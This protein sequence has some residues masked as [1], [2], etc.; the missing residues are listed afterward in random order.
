MA[1]AINYG[2]SGAAPGQPLP[3]DHP[4]K[5]FAAD[6]PDNHPVKTLFTGKEQWLGDSKY[7]LGFLRL[8]C[9]VYQA[10]IQ[11]TCNNSTVRAITQLDSADMR[12]ELAEFERLF[13]NDV[14][15]RGRKLR[16]RTI[17]REARDSIADLTTDSL[18][19]RAA[20]ESAFDL[21]LARLVRT[22]RLS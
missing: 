22:V 2:T 7:V 9:L 1:R 17:L 12:F 21:T 15:F 5:K 19:L 14:V 10:Y 4:A 6:L 20:G 16:L 18:G 13:P 3:D 8:F 11:K